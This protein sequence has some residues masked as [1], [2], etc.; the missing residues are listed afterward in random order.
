M[1]KS[2][3][4]AWNA[5]V[6]VSNN[7]SLYLQEDVEEMSTSDD[8]EAQGEVEQAKRFAAL[9]KEQQ[10]SGGDH[11]KG[12]DHGGISD[13]LAELNMDAYDDEDEDDDMKR[14][15]GGGHPGMAY[16]KNPEDDPYVEA[17]DSE[18]EDMEFRDTDLLIAAARNDE[19]ISY[20]E[21]WVYEEGDGKSPEGN[22][23]VHH[24]LLLPAFPLCLAWGSC[25]PASGNVHGNFIAVGSFEPGIEVWNLDII[26]AVEPVTTL[27]GA[28]YEEARRLAEARLKGKKKKKKIPE[29]PVKSGSHA[30]AVLGLAWNQ[31]FCNVLASG[32]GRLLDPLDVVLS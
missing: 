14:I 8:D 31:E 10:Q 17:G 9:L 24:S 32:S 26:D 20:L 21:V 11:A 3:S 13:S 18:S 29:V 22:I 16:Y 4:R 12:G 7:V 19:D 23:Y 27:G 2:W 1:R 25:D 15:L 28:N 6:S 30:D 5:S